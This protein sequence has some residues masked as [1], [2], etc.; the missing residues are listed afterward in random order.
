MKTNRWEKKE[1]RGAYFIWTNQELMMT[2]IP[3]I[4]SVKR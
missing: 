3:L 2:P 1:E 4:M